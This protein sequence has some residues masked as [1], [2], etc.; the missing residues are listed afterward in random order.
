[1]ILNGDENKAQMHLMEGSWKKLHAVRTGG[2]SLAW[3]T[4]VSEHATA[5]ATLKYATVKEASG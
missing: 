3:M 1:M 4:A 2:V 5:L